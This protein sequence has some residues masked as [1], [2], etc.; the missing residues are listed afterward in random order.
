[1]PVELLL[2]SKC[3]NCGIRFFAVPELLPE[4]VLLLCSLPDYGCKAFPFNGPAEVQADGKRVLY[5][6]LIL[7][8]DRQGISYYS[9]DHI[10]KRAE[11]ILEEYILSRDGLTK[12]T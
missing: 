8:A 12:K 10:C 6:F 9:Y 2:E 3:S 4:T 11:C 7:V 5:L 1:L